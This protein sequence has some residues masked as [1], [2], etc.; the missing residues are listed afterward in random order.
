[1]PSSQPKRAY[2]SAGM[3]PGAGRLVS[4][5]C[6]PHRGWGLTSPEAPNK[7]PALVYGRPRL[8]L[9]SRPR[10][11]D[12]PPRR[13]HR[14]LRPQPKNG[15]HKATKITKKSATRNNGVRRPRPEHSRGI[16]ADSRRLFLLESVKS[17]ESADNLFSSDL[18]G[19]VASC[20]NQV[21]VL[22]GFA[23]SRDLRRKTGFEQVLIQRGLRPQP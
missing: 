2:A 7:E 15:S 1:M 22:Q 12:S 18:R 5:A 11:G 4:S 8:A 6:P 19:F 21:F 17:V 14:G 16:N 3:A 13:T 20:E 10:V 23:S 9:L